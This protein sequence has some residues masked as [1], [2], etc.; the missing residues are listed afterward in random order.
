MS[1][2]ERSKTG[3]LSSKYWKLLL[4]IV[5]GLFTFGGPYAAYVLTDILRLNY[6]VSMV[7]GFALFFVGLIL[8]WYLIRNKVF[9]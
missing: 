3:M 2:E 9:S 4:V 6:A 8:I 5:S 7:F 1:R